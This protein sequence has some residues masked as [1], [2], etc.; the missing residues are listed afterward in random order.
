MVLVISCEGN[1]YFIK[2]KH[3]KAVKW[4]VDLSF[5]NVVKMDENFGVKYKD[6]FKLYVQVKDKVKFESLLH[7]NEVP[8][9]S[10]IN[11]QTGPNID[12]RY[13]LLDEDRPLIDKIVKSNGIIASTETILLHDIH[14]TKKSMK[15]SFIVILIMALITVIAIIFFG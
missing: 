3:C 6:H 15:F 9:Y 2:L 1:G 14:D 13:F 11:D 5:G 10:D 4:A 12:V 7:T 8:F